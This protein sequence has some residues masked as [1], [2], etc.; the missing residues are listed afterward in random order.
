MYSNSRAKCMGFI[1]VS[2]LQEDYFAATAAGRLGA[3]F[4][5]L[6]LIGMRFF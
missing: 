2:R 1:Y 4:P 6:I 3:Y 5:N